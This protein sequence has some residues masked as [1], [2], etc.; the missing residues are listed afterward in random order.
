MALR[1][2][3]YKFD[4]V[5]VGALKIHGE[6]NVEYALTGTWSVVLAC[7]ENIYNEAGD[8]VPWPIAHPILSAIATHCHAAIQSAVDEAIHWRDK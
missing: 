8:E 3:I 5:P 2:L 4:A 7:V 6:S 1:E